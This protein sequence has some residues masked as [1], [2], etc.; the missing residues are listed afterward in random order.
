MRVEFLVSIN[1]DRREAGSAFMS[2]LIVKFHSAE[3]P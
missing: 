3:F 2:S 1:P